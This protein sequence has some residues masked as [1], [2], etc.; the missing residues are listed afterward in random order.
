MKTFLLIFSRARAERQCYQCILITVPLGIT[1]ANSADTF[2]PI[3]R[4]AS[5]DLRMV[6]LY[7]HGTVS[8]NGAASPIPTENKSLQLVYIRTLQL[9]FKYCSKC[10]K[11][12]WFE[13]SALVTASLCLLAG[14]LSAQDLGRQDS[15]SIGLYYSCSAVLQ[16]F[17]CF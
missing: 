4:P 11:K 5:S 8:K 16:V 10:M 9:D 6:E 2:C 17:F 1:S 14:L 3:Q 12:N 13:F 7:F 15:P